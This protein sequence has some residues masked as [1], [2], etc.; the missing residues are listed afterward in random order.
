MDN[1]KEQSFEELYNQSLKDTK[2]E[3]TVTG[4]VISITEKEN[5]CRY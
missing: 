3:K 4:K 5:F 2:L 1:E